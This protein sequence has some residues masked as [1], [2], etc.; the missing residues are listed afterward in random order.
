MEGRINSTKEFVWLNLP[1]EQRNF[2]VDIGHWVPPT[3]GWWDWAMSKF[4]PVEKP[5]VLREPRVLGTRQQPREDDEEQADEDKDGGN[6]GDDDDLKV[7]EIGIKAHRYTTIADGTTE[8]I[9]GIMAKIEKVAVEVSQLRATLIVGTGAE[10]E[11]GPHLR[12]REV[13]WSAQEEYP[14]GSI[15]LRSVLVLK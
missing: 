5:L 1:K 10:G 3:L 14:T 9:V 12:N 15:F 7:K 4:G 8:D 6:G 13:S 2:V 11:I